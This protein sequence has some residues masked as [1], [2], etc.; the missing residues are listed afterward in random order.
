M[1]K[2]LPASQG[3]K[4]GVFT[5]KTATTSI[6]VHALLI[7]G[8]VYASV[9][10][11]TEQEKEE[12]LVEFMEI[13]DKPPEPEA[14]KPDEPP[15]PPPPE[16]TEAPPPPKGFQTLMPPEEPPPVIPEVDTSAPPVSAADF[17][18]IGQAG[19]TSKGV[20][21]GVPQAV[22]KEEPPAEGFAY[23]VAV[24][25]RKPELSNRS[26]VA[27]LMQ[28][29]YPRMLQ[30]AGIGGTVMM[31]FIIEAN[32]QVEASSVKVIDSSHEQF[33]DA[34]VKAVEKFRFKPGRYKGQNVRVLIQMPITWQPER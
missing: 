32:G 9:G 8:A 24:L 28:R 22:A 26:Q 31:Q 6:V 10:G 21:G 7:A 25:E 27:S 17:S 4:R 33:A 14:P 3:S 15:P 13:E 19:G 12:E 18:G 30:D 11:P 2:N 16:P 1:F 23:E 34:S 5:G 29:L 20:E